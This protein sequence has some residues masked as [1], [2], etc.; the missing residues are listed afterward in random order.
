MR[1][2]VGGRAK[3]QSAASTSEIAR[4]ETETL[5]TKQNLKHLTDLP[6]KSIDDAHR[7]R[8]LTMLILD[9]DS[10]LSENLRP[11]GGHW[12]QRTL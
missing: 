8:T 10:S 7:H 2:V 9:V 5:S 3:D 1:T 6:G 4:F 12:L 11:A